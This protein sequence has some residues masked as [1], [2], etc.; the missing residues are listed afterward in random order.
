VTAKQLE[1][2]WHQIFIRAIGCNWLVCLAIYMGMQ[3]KDV[4]SKVMGMYMPVFVFVLLGFDHV[5]ANMFFIP[6][7]LWLGTPGL[8]IGLYIWKGVIPAAIGN[9]IGGTVFCAGYYYYMY[10]YGEPEI[11]LDG[12]Y[13]QPAR[14]E[15]GTISTLQFGKSGEISGNTTSVDLKA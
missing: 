8:T 9:M 6:L 14:L 4:V 15:E 2:Q 3:G 11:C 13:Y 12:T 1:P 5:A 10:I 7:G